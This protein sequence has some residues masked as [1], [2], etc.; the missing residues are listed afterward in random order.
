LNDKFDPQKHSATGYIVQMSNSNAFAAQSK[1]HAVQNE[2]LFRGLCHSN[3]TP[4][5][6]MASLKS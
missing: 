4:S 3:N 5:I 6:D 1:E 2:I